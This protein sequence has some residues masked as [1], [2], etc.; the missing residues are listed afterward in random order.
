MLGNAWPEAPGTSPSLGAKLIKNGDLREWWT[1]M[2][3]D[4]LLISSEVKP[5]T[6]K[7]ESEDKTRGERRRGTEE[8]FLFQPPLFLICTILTGEYVLISD[9]H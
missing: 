1:R 3:N 5:F 7:T 4:I 2:V 8:I 6:I 9:W